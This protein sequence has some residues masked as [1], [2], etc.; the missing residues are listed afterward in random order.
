MSAEVFRVHHHDQVKYGLSPLHLLFSS[1]YD[2]VDKNQIYRGVTQ[3]EHSNPLTQMCPK[4][5]HA[6]SILGKRWTGL[7][8]RVLLTGPVR[9]KD[10]RELVP[11]LSDK[12]LSERLKELEE[13]GI[14]ERKVYPEMPVR[15]EY[16]LTKK[17]ADLRPV[18]ES[19][20]HWSHDWVELKPG[21]TCKE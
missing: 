11:Q 2:T 20:E 9:F 5:E 10:I 14:I 1:K 12:M 17:G 3:M 19:I 21:D 6:I 13:E 4:Y 8:I 18:I 15:I 16:E 7:I